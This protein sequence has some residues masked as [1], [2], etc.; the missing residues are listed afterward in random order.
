MSEYEEIKAVLLR[1]CVAHTASGGGKFQH[2]D[3][4]TVENAKTIA[5]GQGMMVFDEVGRHLGTAWDDMGC[6]D[7]RETPND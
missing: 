6:W 1:C 7:E 3:S 5:V 4:P 2:G